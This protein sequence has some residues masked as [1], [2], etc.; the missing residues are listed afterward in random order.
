MKRSLRYLRRRGPTR[1]GG[2]LIAFVYLELWIVAFAR[3]LIRQEA[4]A[5]VGR[6][7][8]DGLTADR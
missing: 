3:G 2:S 6:D 5:L 4:K 8:A 1:K 7:V